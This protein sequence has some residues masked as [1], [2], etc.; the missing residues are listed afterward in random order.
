M[1]LGKCTCLV[2]LLAVAGLGATASRAASGVFTVPPELRDDV[3]FW[4]RIYADVTTQEGL[5]HDDRHLAVVYERVSVPAAGAARAAVVAARKQYYAD[6]LSRLAASS[7]RPADAEDAR[8]LAL[9]PGAGPDELAAAALRIRF[10]L[11]QSDRFRE[12]LARSGA[13]RPYIER[14]LAEAGLPAELAA[15]PHVE[16]SFNP[17]AYSK[18]GAAGMW[19]F[20]RETGRQY[21][22]VDAVVDER[23]DPA[24]S[25]R[26]AAEYLRRAYS[27]LGSWPHALVSYNHGVNGMA[28]AVEQHGRDD[29]VRVLRQYQSPTFKFASRNFYPSFLAALEVEQNAAVHFPGTI[30]TPP[31]QTCTAPIVTAVSASTLASRLALPLQDLQRLNPALRPPVWTGAKP[32]PPGYAFRFMA[33][34][35]SRESLSRWVAVPEMRLESVAQDR[36]RPA[37]ASGESSHFESTGACY[38]QR[39]ASGDVG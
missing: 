9:W 23:L 18:V 11:G 10:Q 13:W 35:A 17:Y 14:V 24:V 29:I 27:R 1:N 38:S 33:G 6:R 21:M 15:L 22:R 4:V 28:R 19:Q 8:V 39:F 12:G 16:S 30:T 34:T 7:L 5:I 20:T 37:F 32:L 3:S 31:W 36:T 2:L 26:A 25:T